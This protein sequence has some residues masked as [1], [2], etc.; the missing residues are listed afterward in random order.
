MNPTSEKILLELLGRILNRNIHQD[1][2][3]ELHSLDNPDRKRWLEIISLA[4]RQEVS[5][6]LFDA[7]PS[8]PAHQR[9]D[10][11]VMM[12]WSSDIIGMERSNHAYRKEMFAMFDRLAERRLTPI[13]LKGVGLAN[14]Y[15]NP[16][17]RPVGDVD[18]FVTLDHQHQFINCFQEAGATISHEYDNKHTQLQCNGLNWEL[19][20]HSTFFYHPRTE[21]NYRI[22]EAEDTSSDMLCHESIDGNQITVFPPMLNIIYLTAHFQHHLILEYVTLRQVIDLMLALHRERT[23]LGIGEVALMHQLERLNLLKLYRAIGYIATHYLG[24]AAD[25]YAGLSHLTKKDSRRGELLLRIIMQGHI[26]G[27]QPYQTRSKADSLK[28][29]IQLYGELIKRCFA[30]RRLCPR[31]CRATPLGFAVKA[32]KRRLAEH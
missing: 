17:H 8:L 29:R 7:I 15:P 31:E 20:F 2:E 10:T 12:R 18:L 22:L 21:H 23:A 26:P 13:V 28:T 5:G 1:D 11:E 14:N 3:D 24:F 19:H 32:I 30:L 4:E 27:C 6:L 25:S 9:P 16:L